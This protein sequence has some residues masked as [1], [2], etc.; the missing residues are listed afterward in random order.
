MNIHDLDLPPHHQEILERFIT[1]CQTDERIVAAF[2][3][4]SYANQKA[5]R[6]SDLDLFFVTLDDAYE[7]FLVEREN[8][9]RLLGDPLFLDDFGLPHGYCIIFSNTTECD[10]WF[11]RER[12]FQDI[13][14]GPYKVLL[15]KKGVLAGKN[16]S[17]RAAN[18]AKQIELLRQQVDWFWHELSHFIKAMGRRQLWFAYGQLEAMRQICVILARLRY[19]FTDAYVGGEPYF[20]IE[21]ALPIEKLSSLQ[22]TFCT[23]EYDAM[24]QA[25][26][27]L[28]RFYQ[29]IAPSLADAHHL[30]YQVN[31]ERLMM[32]KLKKLSV[33]G[34]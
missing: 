25:A 24:V 34:Q 18:Q 6:F 7:N 21:Q 33:S 30:T 27:A 29:D 9:I 10:I 22:T 23:M 4:G 16:F 13:Y 12:N 11:G 8:F 1:A 15:D 31:L 26:F 5:D 2:L 17:S 28:C 3:G 20:K 32:N 14:Y 19:N